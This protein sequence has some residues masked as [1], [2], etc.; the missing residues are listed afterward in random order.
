MGAEFCARSFSKDMTKQ[1]VREKVAEITEEMAYDS[2]H[3]Y[4][5]TW[6]SAAPGVEF[7]GTPVFDSTED[8]EE[9]VA[10]NHEKWEQVMAVKYSD[11]NSEGWF[12]GGWCS[13]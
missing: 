3:S 5:G 7:P 1:E 9:W 11:G 2:G 6:A 4:S 8:A 13:S 10:E 12:V